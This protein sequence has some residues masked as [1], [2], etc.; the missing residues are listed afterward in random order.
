MR[1]GP[2]FFA[3][4]D[5]AIERAFRSGGAYAISSIPKRYTTSG[6]G[7]LLVRFQGRHP[8]AE[9][10]IS[11]ASSRLITAITSDQR[12]LV[13]EAIRAAVGRGHGAAPTA[14]DLVGRICPNGRRTAGL[15]GPNKRHAAYTPN[16]RDE[17]AAPGGGYFSRATRDTRFAGPLRQALKKHTPIPPADTVRPAGS[18]SN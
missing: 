5:D 17:P 10:W 9:A 2:E 14:L 4:L 16:P 12:E 1:L 15:L 11:E 13:R 6:G 7:P 18:A 8:R 3:P